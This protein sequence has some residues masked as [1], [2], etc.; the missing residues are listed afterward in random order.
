MPLSFTSIS[1]YL[2]C[3]EEYN[4]YYNEKIRPEQINSAMYFGGAIDKAFTTLITTKNLK[5]TLKTFEDVFVNDPLIVYHENDLDEEL[6]TKEE[7]NAA[8]YYSLKAKG[9]TILTSLHQE[10]IPR[11]KKVYALQERI[12]ITNELG[13]SLPII[14]DLVCEWEDGRVILFDLK[15]SIIEY[16]HDSARKSQQLSLYYHFLKDRYPIT[17]LGFIVARKTLK[18]NRIKMCSE[19]SFDGT[20]GSHRTCPNKRNGGR[21][22]A[23]WTVTIRPEA[24][25]QVIINS[26]NEQFVQM[27]LDTTDKISD[28]I[29]KNNY[30]R[31]L[32]SC[33]RG[34][35]VCDYYNLCH[36]NDMTGLKRK[37]YKGNK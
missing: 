32:S 18:K 17:H 35:R 20:G 2:S 27:M 37:E 4:L 16:E 34:K 10:I 29:K 21:C 22:R 7:K 23:Q 24:Y 6:I 9:A 11:I 13:D 12:T 33:K 14:A 25:I 15:T 3:P 26:P 30:Y 5:K 19:C 1:K 8:E 36:N 28:N 31:N